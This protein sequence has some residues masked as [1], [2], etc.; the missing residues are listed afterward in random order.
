MFGY[1]LPGFR[2]VRG[3]LVVGVLWAWVVWVWVGPSMLTNPSVLDLLRR[4]GLDALP[5]AAWLSVIIVIAYTVGSLLMIRTT[6][7]HWFG[8]LRWR[9]EDVI[10][11]L[12]DPTEPRRCLRR[13]VWKVWQ[14]PP[15][16]VRWLMIRLN[17]DHA[18]AAS[19]DSHL[20]AE[21]AKYVA[22]G[23]FLITN[24]IGPGCFSDDLGLRGS[25]SAD[26]INSAF[27]AH[28]DQW[29]FRETLIGAFINQ[30]KKDE[31]AVEVRIQM[32]FPDVYNEIDRLRA[33]G[34]LRISIFWPGVLGAASQAWLWSPWWLVA[35][36]PLMGLLVDGKRRLVQASEKT[37]S[38]LIAGEVSSPILDEVK[39]ANEL[40]P[41]PIQ[42][43][44]GL[45]WAP[46]EASSAAEHVSA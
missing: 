14:S 19:I 4:Y 12:N 3:P 1:V 24:N 29:E 27:N 39:S 8:R 31:S 35:V 32:R 25:F 41:A 9:G 43:L 22:Q 46:S 17:E 44:D 15:P 37:W 45:F 26:E 34:E 16:G 5:S 40:N 36:L 28:E 6:P 33:E 20:R 21:H 2:E 13:M 38:C 7:F 42:M 18:A 30:V 23:R 10:R 11:R